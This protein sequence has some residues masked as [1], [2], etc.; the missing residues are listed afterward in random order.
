MTSSKSK[1]IR[2]GALQHAYQSHIGATLNIRTY[3]D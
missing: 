1:R 2:K 3:S